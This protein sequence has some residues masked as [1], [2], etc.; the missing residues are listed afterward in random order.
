MKEIVTFSFRKGSPST[1]KIF[2]PQ[3]FDDTN[4]SGGDAGEPDPGELEM[5]KQIYGT[6]KMSL[7]VDVQGTINRTNA[8]HRE[9]STLTLMDLDFSDI[10]K[11]EEKLLRLA[12]SNMESIEGLKKMMED[13]PGIKVELQDTVEVQFR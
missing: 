6:M 8:S 3:N 2:L 12:S 11:D 10:V 13:V 7:V 4:K 5:M 1:L 9:G